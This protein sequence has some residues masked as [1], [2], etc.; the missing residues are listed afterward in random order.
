MRASQLQMAVVDG[1]TG[2]ETGQEHRLSIVVCSG[3]YVA[4]C[5]QRILCLKL[6]RSHPAVAVSG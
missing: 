3:V 1:V 6:S 4:V 5:Q 2:A